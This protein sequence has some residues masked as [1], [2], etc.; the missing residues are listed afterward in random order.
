MKRIILLL[1]LIVFGTTG[2]RSQEP[3]LLKPIKQKPLNDR[4]V[5]NDT[6]SSRFSSR[7]T[8]NRNI[9][10]LDARIE[11]YK[12]I[13]MDR[14]SIY[15]DTTLSI[16]KEYK[17][18]YLQRDDFNLMP[19]NNLGQTYNTLRYDFSEDG[20]LPLFGARARHFNYMETNDINYYHVPTPLTELLYK[21]AFE[22]GQFIDAFFS[23]NTSRQFNFSVGYKALRSLGKYQHAITSTGNLRL[24]TNYKTKKGNY[25]LRAHVVMQDLLNE[26]NGGIKDE[27]IERFE[28][29]DPEFLDRSI[30]QVNFENAEN[31]LKGRRFYLDH[32][33]TVISKTD[34]IRQ[35]I[36]RFGNVLSF[37]DRYYQFDQT[38]QDDYFGE[39]FKSSD[40]RDKVT[41]EDFKASVYAN[42]LNDVLG[43]LTFSIGFA[44][45]NYGYD[46]VV[47]LDDRTIPNRIKDNVVSVTGNYENDFGK[48][49]LQ[50]RL[51][52][53]ISGEFAGNSITAKATYAINEDNAFSFGITSNSRRP[54]YNFLLYQSD[55]TNYNWY[56]DY[57]NVTTKIVSA[58]VDLK[59]IVNLRIDY[60]T[61]GN[62]T[63]FQQLIEKST[64][65]FQTDQTV[66][67]L[68][69]LL[70]KEL[71]YG[72]FAL[73]NTIAYQNVI[74]GNDI[75]NVPQVTT[76]NTLYFASHFFKKALFLQTGVTLKYFTKY[77]MNAYDPLLAEFYVQNGQEFGGFPMLDFFV[78]AKIRQT[79]IYFKAE[80]FNS[81]FTGYNYYSAPN[82]PYRDFAVRFGLVWNF[83][84]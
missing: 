63:Y 6:S 61:I 35:N 7:N 58:N 52:T 12:I 73:A 38:R 48:L 14:D 10:N 81:S 19:F 41:L 4:G 49:N 25:K 39:A 47:V 30:F 56:N 71:K 74:D 67:Y 79:R 44:D 33:Y 21:T 59:K 69:I 82:N 43:D 17:F 1:I 70:T 23:V 18:N 13:S 29:G 5:T 65:P 31:I 42:Y 53:N 46:K 64:K 83:F 75:L 28:S 54:N 27:E 24:T 8:S 57:K 16:L 36:L 11:D 20:T 55:Y 51:S 15:V 80:H 50:G 34:S 76:R 77:N 62:Y 3:K 68:N 72:K 84:L 40:L 66:N 26:E 32:D 37:E 9:K 22:Q 2:A 60:N 78:N 45:L